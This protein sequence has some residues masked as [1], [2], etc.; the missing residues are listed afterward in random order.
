FFKYYRVWMDDEDVGLLPYDESVEQQSH[1][2]QIDERGT[3]DFTIQAVDEDSDRYSYSNT[4]NFE[5]Y[6]PVLHEVRIENVTIEDEAVNVSVDAGG[7]H[8]DEYVYDL[9]RSR[10]KDQGYDPVNEEPLTVEENEFS[11][12]DEEVDDLDEAIWYYRVFA[13]LIDADDFPCEEP[14]EESEPVST[15]W[16]DVALDEYT[17]NTLQFEV[18]YDRDP[19]DGDYELQQRLPGET[20]FSDTGHPDSG[21]SFSYDLSDEMP[22]SGVFHFRMQGEENPETFYSNVV[23]VPVEPEI[24]IP[25]AFRPASIEEENQTFWVDFVGFSPEKSQMTIYDRN[26]LELFSTD[27]FTNKG[28]GWDG[29]ANGEMMPDGAYI[30]HI[31]Y[32][33]NSGNPYE[34]KGVVYLV[35]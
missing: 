32:E 16:L 14:V 15:L 5:V 33:D 13:H 23:M 3:Y 11:F 19:P 20:D 34:E 31:R 9:K 26:G 29:R 22:I 6:F 12:E 10:E 25:N 8:Y 27:E 2:F 35:R 21:G 18:A 4:I 7:E 30:Y 17:E 24:T 28:E 1:T